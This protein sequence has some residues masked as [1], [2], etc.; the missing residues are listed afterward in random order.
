MSYDLVFW[1]GWPTLHPKQ[2]WMALSDGEPVRFV[3][4]LPRAEVE[5]AFI[6]VFGEHVQVEDDSILGRG[7]ELYVGDDPLRYLYVTCNWGMISDSIGSQI[8]AQ[9]HMACRGKLGCHCYDPQTNLHREPLP[10]RTSGEFAIPDPELPSTGPK[11]GDRVT[12][13]KFGAGEVLAVEGKND[14]AK[15]RVRFADGSERRVLARFFSS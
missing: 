8:I 11:V 14:A 9:I 13:A 5:Q 4:D 6:E 15:L 7:F 10:R 3:A 1:R 12:H 2:V